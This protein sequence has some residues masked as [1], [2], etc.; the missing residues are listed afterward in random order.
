MDFGN[1]EISKREFNK[2][3]CHFKSRHDLYFFLMNTLLQIKYDGWRYCFCNMLEKKE[4][5]QLCV[6]STVFCDFESN[7]RD[8]MLNVLYLKNYQSKLYP[9]LSRLF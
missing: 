2:E 5:C 3:I 8:N 9:H 7:L 4:K 6:I 1:M